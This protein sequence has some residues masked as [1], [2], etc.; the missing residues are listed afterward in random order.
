[1]RRLLLVTALLVSRNAFA[2]QC[3]ALQRYVVTP[4]IPLGCPLVVYQDHEYHLDDP[5]DIYVSHNGV[6]TKITPAGITTTSETLSIYYDTIDDFC[7]EHHDTEMRAW[8][9]IEIDLGTTVQPG[10]TVQVTGSYPDATISIAGEPCA[11]AVPPDNLYCQDPVQDYWQCEHRGDDFAVPDAGIG[12]GGGGGGGGYFG[13]GCNTGGGSLS[14][15]GVAL[16]VG[17]RRRRRASDRR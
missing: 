17:V 4:S 11:V 12:R 14:L 15:A 10:D 16:L 3:P 9:R 13:G 8:D 2:N 6:D 1:M 7:I 5:L